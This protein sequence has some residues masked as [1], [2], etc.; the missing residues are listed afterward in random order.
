VKAV[1]V[2]RLI[3]T[4]KGPM[5]GWIARAYDRSVQTALRQVFREIAQDVFPDMKQIRCGLDAG[6]GPGQF[7]ILI[8][9]AAPQA[10]V[11]GIDLAPTMIELA[12]CHAASSSALGRVHFAVADVCRLPFPDDYFDGVM[13]TGSIKHWLNPKIGLRELHRVLRPGGRAFIAEM[14][15][16]ASPEAIAR[17]RDRL[18]SWFFRW[19]YPRVFAQALSPS[20]GRLMFEASPFGAPVDERMLLGGCVWLFAAEKRVSPPG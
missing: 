18:R 14:N 19:L 15:R 7:T 3:R 20:E 2:I 11:V 6:C 16:A 13:S 12:R 1:E 8:A 17:Q 5:D 9:E 10:K 4:G